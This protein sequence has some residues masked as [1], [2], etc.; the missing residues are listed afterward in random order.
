MNAKK[1]NPHSKQYFNDTRDFWWNKDFLQL[2]ANR[3]CLKDVQ[4][5][6]DVGCGQGHWGLLLLPFLHPAAPPRGRS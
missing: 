2:M 4:K 3:L 5:V 6:L 1:T